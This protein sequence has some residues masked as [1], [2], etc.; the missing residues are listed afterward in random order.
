[1]KKETKKKGTLAEIED[2]RIRLEEAEEALRAIR[3]GEVDALVVTGPQGE[4]VFTL[5]GA[6]QPYRVFIEAMNEGAV[7]LDSQGNI[8]YCNHRFAEMLKTFPE[9]VIGSSIHQFIRPEDASNF[10]SAFQTGKREKTIADVSLKR[11][12]DG[13]LPVHLSFNA[14]QGQVMPVVCM[15]AT[16]L[17]EHKRYEEEILKSHAELEMK[18]QE[19]TA[20]LT[21]INE[22]LRTEIAEREKAEESLRESEHRWATT[23]A[24][25]GDAVI[26]TDADGR[27]RFMNAVAEGLTG[28]T[29]PEASQK[30]IT[31]VFN[32]FNEQTREKVESPVTKILWEGTTTGLAN[33]TV[34]IR[35]DGTEVPIDVSGAPIRDKDGKIVGVVFVFRDITERRRAEEA[36][37]N[38]HDELEQQV[39]ERTSE[40]SDAVERLR[41]ENIQRKQLE[42]TLR[43]SEY[44]VRFFASQRLTAQET[45]RKRV[46]GE[47]HD[48]IAASLGAVKFKIDKIVEEMNQGHGSPESLEDLGSRVTEINNEVRRIM[49]DLR[50]GI[51]DDLGIVA[52]MNWFCREYEKIYTHIPVQKEIGVSEDEIPD[53][54]RTP[55][56][57]ICQEAMNNIA[58]YSKARLVNFSLQE[59]DGRIELTIQDNGKGF[60]PDTV[61]RGM[62]LSTMK[63]RAQLSGGTFELESAEGKGTVIRASWPLN[64]N[65]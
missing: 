15:V 6:E 45:E 16:D 36:S 61:K 60:N 31:K 65:L 53:S 12:N 50:P 8:L 44:Q 3:S 35:K 25:I 56:F 32:L 11:K 2:L 55:I 24:S 22:R 37:K 9:K 19:R 48:S 49:A 21:K 64:Q 30:Q 17:T 59:R 58:K 33:H 46:A 38:A 14:L 34:L 57:R 18:I 13:F 23:L 63:E 10:E 40:L 54:L 42:D 26:A 7:T 47:L 43:Q 27:I 52:A 51:L 39:L 28:W 41:V 20:E 29:L 1:M 5:K 4:E 62:G